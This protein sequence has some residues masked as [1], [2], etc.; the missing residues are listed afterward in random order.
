LALAYATLHKT[1]L[2]IL[3]AALRMGRTH[4][5]LRERSREA[6]MGMLATGLLHNLG[7][8]LNG[9]T[10]SSGMLREKL[11]QSKLGGLHRVAKLVEAE[12][13][14]LP[15]SPHQERRAALPT[16]IRRLADH[17]QCEHAE[18][19][20]EAESIADCAEHAV[21]VIAA[22]QS[23]AKGQPVF[24]ELL[25]VNALMDSALELGWSAFGLQGV[26]I[27]RH[28]ECDVC[29][30][31]DRHRL[32]QILLNLL[33]NASQ[34]LGEVPAGARSIALRT[35]LAGGCVRLTVQDNGSG[36]EACHLPHL[37]NQGFTTKP[38]G[39]GSGLHSSANWA[40][41]LGGC[42][43]GHSD[44][45]GRGASFVLELQAHLATAH[46]PSIAPAVAADA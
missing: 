40:H 6:G 4:A 42:L 23:L 18:L 5:Q 32:L 28:Y 38:H 3:R 33:A 34:A 14:Q 30:M 43:S 13:Q 36:I 22:Q 44:G 25:R 26:A 16:Y 10:V 9:V 19:L 1:A 11:H 39:H 35:S 29:V 21:A 27:E 46:E 31:A 41:E 20:N 7:N 2:G 12:L 15:A 8:V 17:L 37:F 45:P 24:D